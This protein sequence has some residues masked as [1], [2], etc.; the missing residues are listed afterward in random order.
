MRSVFAAALALAFA[1]PASAAPTEAQI[2]AFIAAVEAIGC[3]VQ[4]D[5]EAAQVEEATGYD[6][7]TLGEIVAVLLADG[8]AEIPEAIGGLRLITAACR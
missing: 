7:A 6:D 1:A 2:A 5:V 8:R 4:S 3:V